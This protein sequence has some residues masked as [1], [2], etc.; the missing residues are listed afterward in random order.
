MRNRTLNA[1]WPSV[2][3]AVA[4]VL[5]GL[6]HLLA[7]AVMFFVFGA[8]TGLGS[9]PELLPVYGRLGWFGFGLFFASIPLDFVAAIYLLRSRSSGRSLLATAAILNLPLI[10]MGTLIGVCT[11]AALLLVR[12]QDRRPPTLI[13]SGNRK[14][15]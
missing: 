13:S 14:R 6:L 1:N 5:T 10:P 11:V 12:H 4:Y 3:L 7:A 8:K 2:I 9:Q 15:F